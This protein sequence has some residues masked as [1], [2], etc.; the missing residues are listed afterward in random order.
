MT[1]FR[2]QVY[3]FI[4]IELLGPNFL[5]LLISI[6][7]IARKLIPIQIQMP[8][9]IFRR[10]VCSDNATTPSAVFWPL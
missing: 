3:E 7:P 9:S 1:R 5:F 4:I 2:F 8:D 6:T 10:V